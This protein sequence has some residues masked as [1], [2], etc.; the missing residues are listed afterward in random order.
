MEFVE[1]SYCVPYEIYE[2]II[3]DKGFKGTVRYIGP[4]VAAKNQS[5]IWLGIEW[6]INSRGKHDGSCIDSTGTVV[7][8]F[9]CEVGRGSFVKPNIVKKGRNF[10]E[11]LLERY[12]S[13]DAP[14]TAP[15]AIIPGA[16]VNTI[17]G[18]T[19]QIELVGERKIRER[20]QVEVVIKASVRADTVS[21]ADDATPHIL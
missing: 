13:I 16:Y 20:Q 5:D 3:D 18:N 9:Q 4:V 8:Y 2:R 1:K 10:T 7:R 6:D 14:I 11:A 15:D 19:K 21:T 12:I 17:K